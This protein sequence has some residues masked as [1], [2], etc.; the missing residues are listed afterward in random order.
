M[1]ISDLDLDL[2]LGYYAQVNL[3]S[4]LNLYVYGETRSF[5]LADL[6]EADAG[7]MLA[8]QGKMTP[9]EMAAAAAL[10]SVLV[11]FI[12]VIAVA[13]LC[14]R[15]RRRM[16]SKGQIVAQCCGGCCR[17]QD[18]LAY[19]KK[20]KSRWC[21]KNSRHFE[22]EDILFNNFFPA[23][24]LAVGSVARAG[25]WAPLSREGTSTR[26]TCFRWRRYRRGTS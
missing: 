25:W 26:G 8:D 19:P 6:Q 13:L 9:G 22:G 2:S 24:C 16:A 15:R 14:V 11:I 20:K 23:S 3:V 7:S 21:K 5:A 18:P 12:L 10:G 1:E 17:E 4:P